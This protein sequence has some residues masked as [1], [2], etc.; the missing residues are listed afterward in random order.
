MSFLRYLVLMSLTI[1]ALSMA[2]W[3]VGFFEGFGVAIALSG[4][5]IIWFFSQ[6]RDRITPIA[7]YKM[8]TL[9][10]AALWVMATAGHLYT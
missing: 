9:T 5:P 8:P 4:I 10:V 6:R 2:V 3:R 1:A 7:D